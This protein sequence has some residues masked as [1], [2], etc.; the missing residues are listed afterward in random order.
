M[1]RALRIAWIAAAL[2]AGCAGAPGVREPV[3]GAPQSRAVPPPGTAPSPSVPRRAGGYYQDDGPGENPP[4]DLD[5]IAD[6][7]PRLEPLHR[8]ANNP[9]SVFGRE[10]VPRRALG[11]YRARGVASWYGR[12]FHGQPT[13]SS[14]PYDMYAMTAAHP[15]LPIPSY[16][17]VT[18]LDDGRSV[19]VRI[20]DRGPFLAERLIDLSFA[21]AYRLGYAQQGFARVE[22]ESVMPEGAAAIAPDADPIAELVERLDRDAQQPPSS[23]DARAV[24]LQ[25]GAFSSRDHA[26]SFRNR[27]ARELARLA[28]FGERL[29]V[30][31]GEGMYR[32][33]LGPYADPG[34][35]AR[36]AER[37]GQALGVKPFALVR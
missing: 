11:P 16:A 25:L 35:A 31:P 24:F 9:Y 21:A 32:V 17:R 36:A 3:P 22:V 28:G 4:N 34:E 5:A 20:N 13:S 19:V 30:H 8:Y 15:T 18:R 33:H 7:Q 29:L 23:T 37:I 1:T 10:Y 27:Y 2:L 6:A 14:E 12:K 26:E